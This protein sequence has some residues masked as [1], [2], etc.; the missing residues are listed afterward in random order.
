MEKKILRAQSSTITDD[1]ELIVLKTELIVTVISSKGKR[2]E[3]GRMDMSDVK[4]S[5][6]LVSIVVF[7]FMPP[8]RASRVP[9]L[10]R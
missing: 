6:C 5:A 8:C 9:F 2:E 3:A 1:T 4:Q 7:P 10:T